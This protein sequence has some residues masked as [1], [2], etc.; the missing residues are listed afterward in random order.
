[1]WAGLHLSDAAVL[2]AGFARRKGVPP[3]S[4]DGAWCSGPTAGD[5]CV[6]EA[7]PGVVSLIARCA[8]GAAPGDFRLPA[9][10]W[11]GALAFS[12]RCARAL[13]NHLH[14]A[15]RF[16]ALSK[17][18]TSC[19]TS[20]TTRKTHSAGNFNVPLPRLDGRIGIVFSEDAPCAVGCGS[21]ASARDGETSEGGGGFSHVTAMGTMTGCAR[22]G[23]R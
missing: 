13:M 8:W 20:E 11:G 6:P 17:F 16:F 9:G 2:P 5:P 18:M 15:G 19:V 22:D 12:G 14:D 7:I 21:V 3:R 10:G 1:M 4:Q 23:G